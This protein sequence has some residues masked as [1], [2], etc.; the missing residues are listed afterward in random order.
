MR[1]TTVCELY[2]LA[3]SYRLGRDEDHPIKQAIG[4][5]PVLHA[6]VWARAMVG[7]DGRAK[8]LQMR[9]RDRAVLP[10]AVNSDAGLG[11]LERILAVADQL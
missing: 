3:S 1:S 5:W 7:I 2:L 6:S 9:R 10:R 8:G 4:P 11:D